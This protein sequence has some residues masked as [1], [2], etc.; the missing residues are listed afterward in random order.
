MKQGTLLAHEFV[1]F[2][3]DDLREATLYVSMKYAIVA[4]RCCCGCR[5]EVVTPLSPRDWKLLFDGETI[6]L[7]PSIGNWGFDCQSHYWIR[8]SRVNWAPRWSQDRIDAIRSDGRL[9]KGNHSCTAGAT[10]DNVRIH[11]NGALR[12]FWRWLKQWLP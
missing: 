2:I 4:H 6:S 1:E 11:R 10:T 3:P 8:A 5:S 7:S 9:A 12:M